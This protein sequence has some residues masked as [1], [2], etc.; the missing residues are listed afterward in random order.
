MKHP[1]TEYIENETNIEKVENLF[2]K[3]HRVNFKRHGNLVILKYSKE[4][5]ENNLTEIESKCRGHIFDMD[6]KVLVCNP[7]RGSVTYNEFKDNVPF[8]YCVVE[9]NIEGTLINLYYYNNRWNVSTK[10]SINADESRFR[11]VKTYRQ[12]FDSVFDWKK[13]E[14]NL[15]KKFTYSF[16]L[17]F[18]D[19]KLV[20]PINNT[21]LHH[22]ETI[23]N[24]TN[25]NVFIDIGIKHPKIIHIDNSING[26]NKYINISSYDNLE[27]KLEKLNYTERGYMLYSK[28]RKY[29]A[30]ML[31][32]KYLKVLNMIKDQS[33]VNYLCFESAY[34]KK[35]K[36]DIVKYLPEYHN[37]FNNIELEFKSFIKNLYDIYVKKYCFKQEVTYNNKISKLLSAINKKYLETRKKNSFK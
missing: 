27:K 35:N 22:I 37:K 2:K 36:G 29:R 25:E 13:Y 14:N 28:D 7:Q 21:V 24:V 32:P 34:Y 15:D 4:A 26:I 1:F 17:S 12:V 20:T 10:F 16:V 19:N 23:N 33:D 8:K 9:E 5:K 6:N 11:S 3:E 31:N 18:K 30:S